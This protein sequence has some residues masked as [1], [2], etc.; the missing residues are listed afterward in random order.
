MI[1]SGALRGVPAEG[2]PEN[3]EGGWSEINAKRTCKT[4]IICSL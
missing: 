3:A 4:N 1:I 2:V